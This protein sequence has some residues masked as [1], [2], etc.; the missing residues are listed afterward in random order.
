[1]I[2][3]YMLSRLNLLGFFFTNGLSYYFY[4]F[5]IVSAVS[6]FVILFY[7]FNIVLAVIKGFHPADMIKSI[8]S[9]YVKFTA[10]F[11]GKSLFIVSSFHIII[12][13]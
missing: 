9:V 10:W 8:R 2:L 3:F 13:I 11:T 12:L 6:A 4:F 7:N 1:M 5:N